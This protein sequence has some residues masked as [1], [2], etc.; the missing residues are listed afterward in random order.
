MEDVY[1][2]RNMR[3]NKGEFCIHVFDLK[4]DELKSV[5]NFEGLLIWG[6]FLWP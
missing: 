2:D 4:M 5:R 3:E 6:R 1:D